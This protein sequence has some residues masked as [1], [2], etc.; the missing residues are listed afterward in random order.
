MS[1]LE[2]ARASLATGRTTSQA[3]VDEAV[4]RAADP[5]GQ[6][7]RTFLKR[8]PEG[9]RLAARAA[10]DA[11]AQGRSLSPLAGVPVSV[12]DLF[13]VAG[14]ATLAGSRVRA[15]MPLATRDSAVVQRLRAAGA[16]IVGRTNM[17]EFAYSGLGLNPH[18]GTPLNPFDRTTGRIPGG[19][20]S[21]AAVSVSDGM[22]LVAVATDTG[23][24][25]RIP[26]AFCGLTGFKPTA[27]RIPLDGAYPL[28]PS[29]D[30]VGSIGAS[31]DCCAQLDA[32]LAGTPW[33]ADVPPTGG[34]IRI[35]VV[36]DYVTDDL[37]PE[38][39]RAY[40]AALHRLSASGV[41]IV[42]VRYPE[43]LELPAYNQKGGFA[44]YESYRLHAELIERRGDE[45]DPR[46]ATRILRGKL[47]NERDHEL[48]RRQR[49]EF[50]RASAARLRGFHALAAPT[51]PMIAPRIADCESDADFARLNLLALRN[52]SV[53]NFLD[54]CAISIPCHRAGD[55]PVGLMLFQA[56]HRDGELLALARTL[57]VQLNSMEAHGAR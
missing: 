3:L 17:T 51:V 1:T 36:V 5:S 26:A 34:D 54:G 42:E 22:A 16:A 56:A 44:A 12:K 38:V 57:E 27:A 4:A 2:Q 10:D 50:I 47:M 20:S 49:D 53:V 41:D 24:S 48:L 55:A 37:D 11:R 35:G 52:P 39:A 30:S 45:Y 13:D 46:V 40:E 7:A 8:D 6:G 23:G 33:S 31:V 29:L 32:V 19:S 21:G 18:Y 28:S 15:A 25:A 43:L 14:E 9:A